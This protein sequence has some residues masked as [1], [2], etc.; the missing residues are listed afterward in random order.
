M[1]CI[2]AIT[3]RSKCFMYHIHVMT[4]VMVMIGVSGRG[5][6]NKNNTYN[7]IYS[8]KSVQLI[9]AFFVNIYDY[10]SFYLCVYYVL[11]VV[12]ELF[13]ST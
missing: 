5:R 11:L 4:V 9:E 12:K 10:Y 8:S 2:N 13:K 3:Q 6:N 1:Y 7:I